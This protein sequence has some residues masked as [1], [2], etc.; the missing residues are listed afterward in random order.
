MCILY[1]VCNVSGV[2]LITIFNIGVV[3]LI[4]IGTTLN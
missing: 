1:I 3:N 4:T 2:N